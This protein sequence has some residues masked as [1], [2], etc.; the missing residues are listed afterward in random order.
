MPV[1][2]LLLYKLFK[3]VMI[4][5]EPRSGKIVTI[6]PFSVEKLPDGIFERTMKVI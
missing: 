2:F 5:K 3:Y 1:C 6:M 4:L